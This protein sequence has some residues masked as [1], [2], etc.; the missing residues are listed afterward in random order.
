[1]TNSPG[2]GC[3]KPHAPSAS[4]KLRTPAAPHRRRYHNSKKHQPPPAEP[5]PGHYHCV[6]GPWGARI[7]LSKSSEKVRSCYLRAVE[8]HKRAIRAKDP[9]VRAM[10]LKIENRWIALARSYAT[11]E[12]LADYGA[13][14]RRAATRDPAFERGSE[15]RIYEWAKIKSA[16]DRDD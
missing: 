11:T 7:V 15:L 8:A 9:S 13:E 12:A 1:M 5:E 2:G 4:L 10:W 3:L 16:L 6:R 14:V